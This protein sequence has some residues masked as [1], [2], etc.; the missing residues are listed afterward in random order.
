MRLFT[1]SD[2][3]LLSTFAVCLAMAACGDSGTGGTTGVDGTV[4]SDTQSQ[5]DGVTDGTVTDGTVTDGTVTD[6]TVT[7]VV[8]GDSGSDGT[9]TDGGTD[10]TPADGGPADGADTS[11]PPK[12][13]CDKVVT[14]LDSVP[15]TVTGGLSEPFFVTIP[16]NAVSVAVSVVGDIGDSHQYNLG[17]WV[18]P[19]GVLMPVDWDKNQQNAG[20]LCFTCA[21]RTA[22]IQGAFGA[23]APNNPDATFDAG[24]HSFSVLANKPPSNP[25]GGMATPV[26]DE[27]FVTVQAKVLEGGL[28]DAGTL[29]LN[30]H[31]SGAQGWTAASAPTHPDV[32]AMLQKV[33]EIYAAVGITLGEITYTDIDE[34]F[35][36]VEDFDG[37][38]SDLMRLFAASE[39][40]DNH[41]LNLFFVD[42]LVGPFPGFG[43][44][45]GI[46]GGIP[47]PPL[48]H[49]TSRSGVAIAIKPI[50]QVPSGVE[51]TVAHEMGHF[52]GLY[53]T[54]EQ[55]FF[56]GPAITDPL[57]DTPP[58]DDNTYLMHNMGSGSTLSPWQGIVMRSNPWVCHPDANT[59]G[60]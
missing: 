25:F 23:I 24:E 44:V 41:H 30:L 49:G 9:P 29:H 13:G 21:L 33:G 34:E 35:Q 8:I 54:I 45:L 3:R 19:G 36:V 47:G 48:L 15:V 11:T 2:G 6:G 5:I 56:G 57:P 39:V 4:G 22:T 55:N 58:T 28:P 10:G 37:P 17:S 38:N 59:G 12:S 7:D 42:E 43:F 26:D 18:E 31:F 16:E 50:P 27:V 40:Q 32:Q 52:L 51:T 46:S 1:S 53:H 14:L 60:K 20:G